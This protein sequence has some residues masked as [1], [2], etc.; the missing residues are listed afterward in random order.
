[1]DKVFYKTFALAWKMMKKWLE[2]DYKQD[3]SWEILATDASQAYK[4][5]EVEDEVI[6][7][8]ISKIIICATEVIEELHDKERL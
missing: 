5:L 7:E 8:C 3:H 6:N 4:S 1:M 2:L